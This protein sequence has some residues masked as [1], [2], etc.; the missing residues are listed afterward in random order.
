MCGSCKAKHQHKNIKCSGGGGGGGGGGSW[1]GGGGCT[2]GGSTCSSSSSS[3]SSSLKL[4]RHFQY[5]SFGLWCM[6]IPNVHLFFAQAFFKISWV[7]FC[8]LPAC[9]SLVGLLC[10]HKGHK[11]GSGR[12]QVKLSYAGGLLCVCTQT[13]LLYCD[14]LICYRGAD[15][16]LARPTFRCI[17]FDGQSISFDASLVICIYK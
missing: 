7:A 14:S 10:Y 2:G 12:S 5:I 16:S 17:L 13:V 3:S 1:D 11:S 4:L 8:G 9:A 15:R 6:F